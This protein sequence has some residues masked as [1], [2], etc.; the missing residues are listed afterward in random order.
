MI[1]NLFRKLKTPSVMI[2]L[3]FPDLK[4][5]VLSDRKKRP[6]QSDPFPVHTPSLLRVP[7]ESAAESQLLQW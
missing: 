7:A 3:C 2:L 5:F 6:D 1:Q 4:H